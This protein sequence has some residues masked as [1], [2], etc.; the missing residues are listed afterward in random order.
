M[1]HRS[2]LVFIVFLFF[3]FCCHLFQAQDADAG[4]L[5]RSVARVAAKKAAKKAAR[6]AARKAAAKK[7]VQK[8]TKKSIKTKSTPTVNKNGLQNARSHQQLVDRIV[9]DANPVAAPGGK[10]TKAQR[11]ALVQNLPTVQ[12]RGAGAT[13]AMRSHFN[14][15]AKNNT[16][17]K[18]TIIQQWDKKT[19]RNWPQDSKGRPA[20]LHHIVPLESGG[21][22]KWWNAM[23]TFGSSPNHSLSGVA[24]PHARGGVLRKTIQAPR[25]T[26]EK[27]SLNGALRK[28]RET[29]LR[30]H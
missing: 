21:A 17:S 13:K 16:N 9:K 29:D 5:S 26:M 23:P 14:S 20:T 7:A 15:N 4:I 1:L 22:N 3:C 6:K 19:D 25:S 30:S 8:A 18:K 27:S 12:R 11:T 28:F 2:Y 10:I 24:G